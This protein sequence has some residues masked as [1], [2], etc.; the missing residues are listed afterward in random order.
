[1]IGVQERT[2]AQDYEHED[3]QNTEVCLGGF[4]GEPCR[5]EEI[6]ALSS[7]QKHPTPV[8]AASLEGVAGPGDHFVCAGYRK[9]NSSQD[10]DEV[11]KMLLDQNAFE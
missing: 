6:Q 7:G 3:K 8:V 2:G 10:K 4:H 9:T 11:L 1:L 5:P